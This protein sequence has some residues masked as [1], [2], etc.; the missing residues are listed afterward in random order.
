MGNLVKGSLDLSKLKYLPSD[1]PEFPHLLL[2]D[3]DLLFNRTNSP[4]LVGKAAVYRGNP[5]EC[6]FASYLIRVRLSKHF[7]PELLNYFL[8][9]TLGRA[10]VSSVV[11]QQ[12][13]QANVNGSKLKQLTVP[14]PPR[15]TQDAICDLAEEQLTRINELE[16]R[17]SEAGRRVEVFRRS[18]LHHA[19]TGQLVSQDAADESTSELIERIGVEMAPLTA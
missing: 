17:L 2:D 11:S 18:V 6:S 15:E 14:L 10:W 8:G 16:G 1:H 13:G 7:R 4:E 9:S 5:S 19:F 3:G 12:V